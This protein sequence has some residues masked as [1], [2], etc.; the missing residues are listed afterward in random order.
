M[1]YL[2]KLCLQTSVLKYFQ[3]TSDPALELSVWD[4]NRSFGTKNF[5][6]VTFF[7]RRFVKFANSTRQYYLRLVL[8]SRHGFE[9][10]M[11]ID[12]NFIKPLRPYWLNVTSMEEIIVVEV[13]Q[14]LTDSCKWLV[15]ILHTGSWEEKR[16]AWYVNGI[17]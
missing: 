5:S 6:F 11:I 12:A 17:Y 10:I 16:I 1:V 2:E 8:L 3:L 4:F 14:S 7:R 9:L 15:P 13:W